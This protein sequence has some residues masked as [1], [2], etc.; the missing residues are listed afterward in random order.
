[1][2]L[3]FNTLGTPP[4]P[5]TYAFFS[6]CRQVQDWA[7]RRNPIA[8]GTTFYIRQSGSGSATGGTG[9][10]TL[11]TP[12]LVRNCNDL[13][14]LISNNQ[15]TGNRAFLLRCGDIY[16]SDTTTPASTACTFTQP[17]CTLSS[18]VDTSEANYRLRFRPPETTAFSAPVTSGWTQVGGTPWWYRDYAT[19][20]SNRPRGIRFSD[21]DINRGSLADVFRFHDKSTGGAFTSAADSELTTL[22]ADTTT[23][24]NVYTLLWVSATTF[25][26]YIKLATLASPNTA[27]SLEVLQGTGPGISVGNVDGCRLH[28]IN[29]TGWGRLNDA[30]SPGTQTPPILTQN[31]GNT[32]SVVSSCS[33]FYSGTHLIEHYAAANGGSAL[34]LDCVAGYAAGSKVTTATHFE[35]FSPATGTPNDGSGKNE[36]V[37]FR[38]RISHACLPVYSFSTAAS[39]PNFWSAFYNHTGNA[40]NPSDCTI[41]V[42][43]S[44]DPNLKGVGNFN[45]IGGDVWAPSNELDPSTY[46]GIGANINVGAN[47]TANWSYP[48]RHVLVNCRYNLV[49]WGTVD[50]AS[51]LNYNATGDN[52]VCIAANCEVFVDATSM[53]GSASNTYP[54]FV[55]CSPSGTYFRPHTTNTR[56]YFLFKEK[57]VAPSYTN[58]TLTNNSTGQGNTYNVN[59]EF[60][61]LYPTEAGIHGGTANKHTTTMGFPN[62]QATTAQGGYA[63]CAF[64]NFQRIDATTGFLG[65]DASN[66]YDASNVPGFINAP[67]QG[68]AHPLLVDRGSIH[69]YPAMMPE[70]DINGFPRNPAAPQIGPSLPTSAI[71]QA[72]VRPM[73]GTRR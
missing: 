19:D 8:R 7:E 58:E 26:I 55:S 13:A 73:Y 70:F 57:N 36:M 32:L 60:Y 16:Y 22:L 50:A 4:N 40:A 37:G 30:N 24:E 35:G 51:A 23:A 42:D 38:C 28:G 53:S 1:M 21:A 67:P 41:F 47:T 65:Y 64:I 20:G 10:G 59:S 27:T 69:P 54:T 6:W 66:S 17:N 48:N 71:Y 5:L 63:S 49:R 43:C 45:V 56:F 34:F 68:F 29:S 52:H 62:R 18:W 72:P 33:S 12:W 61:S 9:N 46:R 3:I 14:T 25:R 44:V 11:A 31:S 15:S 2:G 39:G